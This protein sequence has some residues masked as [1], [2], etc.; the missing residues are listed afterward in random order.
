MVTQWRWLE[1]LRSGLLEQR[2]NQT[3]ES[4][5]LIDYFNYENRVEAKG[6][7]GKYKMSAIVLGPAKYVK[8]PPSNE[9]VTAVACLTVGVSTKAHIGCVHFYSF[10]KS[11]LALFLICFAN[12][13]CTTPKW[14][15]SFLEIH[16]MQSSFLSN[17]QDDFYLWT[18]KVKWNSSVSTVTT[19]STWDLCLK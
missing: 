8:L 6:A 4:S 2:F 7:D 3:T 11:Y 18:M 9:Y 10:R 14:D 12:S 13:N 19:I 16:R 15:F 17:L 1:Q 5:P